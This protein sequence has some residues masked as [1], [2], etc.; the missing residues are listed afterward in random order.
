MASNFGQRWNM[1]KAMTSFLFAG[2]ASEGSILATMIGPGTRGDM[3]P[4]RRREEYLKGYSELPWLRAIV[5]RVAFSVAAQPWNLYVQ[6]PNGKKE[7]YEQP[8]PLRTM[9]TDGIPG[10]LSG[11]NIVMLTQ[12]W[13]DLV[14]DAFWV[15]RRNNAGVPVEAWPI[16]PH[17]VL[18]I[19]YQITPND[20]VYRIQL[21]NG[22]QAMVP[23]SEVVWFKDVDPLNPYMRGTSTAVAL[24]DEF[25]TDEL[26]S[27]YVSRFF[28]N[29]ARPDLI[30]T[31]D[32]LTPETVKRLDEEWNRKNQGVWNAFR[33][34]FLNKKVDIKELQTNFQHMQLIELRKSERDTIIHVYG[35]PP[36]ILGILEHSNRATI[37]AADYHFGRWVLHPRL[38]QFDL[39]MNFMVRRE[40]D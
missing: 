26:A 1:V 24:G 16:P 38:T 13:W 21:P 31:A 33:T 10:V 22:T 5:H 7:K 8:H 3:L 25:N 20:Q 14:G 30:V 17:W 12:M 2:R 32:G 15:L 39:M 35:I 34:F 6:R 40:Y 4:R 23:S 37:E 9:L 36:E 27:K 11:F 19:P 28:Y 29:S 18:A